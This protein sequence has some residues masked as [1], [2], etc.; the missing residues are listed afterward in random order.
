[1]D[2]STKK[3][4]AFFPYA[5]EVPKAYGSSKTAHTEFTVYPVMHNTSAS[6]LSGS[7]KR[8]KSG[9]HNYPCREADQRECRHNS[10]NNGITNSH[11]YL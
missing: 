11:P 2:F 1:M 8:Y 4:R 3:K 7:R 10:Y 5:A 9:P 6:V